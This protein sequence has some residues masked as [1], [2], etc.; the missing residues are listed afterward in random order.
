MGTIKKM[1][2]K[3]AHFADE[4]VL[5]YNAF[6]RNGEFGREKR[7]RLAQMFFSFVSF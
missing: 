3:G 1:D 7:Q 2:V 4:Q 5:K 6:G